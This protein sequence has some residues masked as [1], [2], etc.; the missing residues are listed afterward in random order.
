LHPFGLILLNEALSAAACS[1]SRG[2]KMQSIWEM[3]L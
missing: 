1:G 2:R 3:Q